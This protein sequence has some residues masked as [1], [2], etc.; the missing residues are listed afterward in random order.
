[1]LNP[2][3]NDRQAMRVLYTATVIMGVAG[4]FTALAMINVRN[5]LD[6]WWK[7][8]GIFTGGMLG[9]F[10]LGLISRR[11]RNAHAVVAAV[12]G[13]LLIMWMS[14]SQTEGW[15]KA[16]GGYINPLHSFMTIVIGTSSIV[17]V[18]MLASRLLGHS[19]RND[20]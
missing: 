13:I 10:L 16:V 4:T 14:L 20:S 17:L 15:M 1:Y 11:A 19:K 3:A 12:V 5:A 2:K 6:A 7:L 8:Q 18:G 9:L